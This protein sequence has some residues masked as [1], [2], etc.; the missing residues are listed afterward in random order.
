[1]STTRDGRRWHRIEAAAKRWGA[2]PPPA[3]RIPEPDPYSSSRWLLKAR[4]EAGGRDI[5]DALHDAEHLAGLLR[6]DWDDMRGGPYTPT[7]TKGDA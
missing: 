4:A 2:V 3:P 1:M 5:L 6:Q 7:P